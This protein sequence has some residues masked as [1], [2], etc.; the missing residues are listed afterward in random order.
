MSSTIVIHPGGKPV[1]VE[2]D[3]VPSDSLGSFASLVIGAGGSEVILYPTREKLVPLAAA[4]RTAADR[5]V[6][7]SEQVAR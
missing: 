7:L 2:A 1:H 3:L 6:E 5:L 4:L